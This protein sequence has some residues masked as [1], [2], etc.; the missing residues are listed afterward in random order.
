MPVSAWADCQTDYADVMTKLSR[1]KQT[2]IKGEKLDSDSFMRDFQPAFDRLQAGGCASEIMQ[3]LQFV[4][5][6][7]Q[8]YP[9]PNAQTAPS[10]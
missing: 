6:E 9:A 10:P 3:L 7:N 8:M 2:A 4:Q 1:A 5:R